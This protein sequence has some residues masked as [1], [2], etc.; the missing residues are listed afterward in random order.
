MITPKTQAVV[1]LLNNL[2]E[3]AVKDG[4]DAGGAYHQNLEGLSVAA[5]NLLHSLGLSNDYE[6]I[7]TTDIY[8]W[9]LIKIIENSHSFKIEEN[10][11]DF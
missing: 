1:K 6:V 7:T 2:I 9:S 10:N 8:N 3:E 5:D 4:A 11:N